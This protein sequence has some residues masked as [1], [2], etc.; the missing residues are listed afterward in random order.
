M[1]FRPSELVGTLVVDFEGYIY[2]RVIKVDIGPEGP[3]FKIRCL[4]NVQK[5][6]PDI[7]AL[8]QDLLRDLKEK[9]NVSNVQEIYEFIAKELKIQSVT[10]NDLISYAK[11]KEVKIP[12]KEV[13]REVEEEKPDI[14]L[15]DV[16]TINKSELGS[17][18]LVKTP[19]EAMMRGIEPQEPVL[20]QSEESLRGKIVIDNTA[21]ILGKAHSFMMSAEGLSIQV[22]KDGMV[23]KLIPDM[24]S[25]KK[26][27]FSEKTSKEIIK[28]MESL[29]FDQPQ[30][31]NDDKLLTY[32]KMRGYEIPTRLESN[33]TILLYKSSVPWHQIRKIGDV[34]LLNKTLLEVF[35]EE[36]KTKEV[37]SMDLTQNSPRLSVQ[38]RESP[39]SF[40]T[41]PGS[42]A[43]GI[44][45]GTL[46]M[47]S[48]GLVPYIG[49]LFS[50][51]VAGYIA[52][53]WKRGAM[54]G[55]ISGLLGTVMIS[56]I[57]HSLF[58]IGLEGLLDIILP[59]STLDAVIGILRY[60]TSEAFLYFGSMANAIVG[61][62]G[63]VSLG[64]F[65]GR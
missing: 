6:M 57:L 64:F 58:L 29:G 28:D 31:L 42:F 63:G 38:A 27:I 50:G 32:A 40:L 44:Y 35:M 7:D 34:V 41:K 9:F 54:A 16:K 52:R 2:G 5:S 19:I 56:M 30:D 49:A 17:C 37:Y 15:D 1:E 3:V 13:L 4:K 8:K 25:L 10:E 39:I 61:L 26:R 43:I 48:I 24:S 46:L 51:G 23:T 47:I 18:I 45:I 33:K 12:M 11:L 21:K 20:Y 36:P 14:R 55:L 22:G 62:I 65:K 59:S 53:D 60:A